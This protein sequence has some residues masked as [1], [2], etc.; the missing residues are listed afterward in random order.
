M[1][2]VEG[3][4]H[5]LKEYDGKVALAVNVAS[6]CSYVR[7]RQPYICSRARVQTKD[8]YT[9]LVKLYNKYKDDGA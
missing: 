1:K 3:K 8:G 7:M 5:D 6:Q 9:N 2:D 4:S